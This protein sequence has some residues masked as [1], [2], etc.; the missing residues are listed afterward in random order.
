[1]ENKYLFLYNFFNIWYI[2][3][4]QKTGFLGLLKVIGI[5]I[6]I[7][8]NKNTDGPYGLWLCNDNNDLS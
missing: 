4:I 8:T 5:Q 1:M 3:L 2:Y 6:V 7:F